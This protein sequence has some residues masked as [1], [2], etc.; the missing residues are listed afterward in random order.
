MPQN[1]RILADLPCSSS[2]EESMVKFRI[3]SAAA[4]FFA[5]LAGPAMARQ[6]ISGPSRP[7]QS[8]F[9]A[10]REA[11]NP[12]SKYCDY[13][14]WSKWRQRGDWDSTLD[15]ACLRNP[16]FIPGECSFDQQGRVLFSAPLNWPALNSGATAFDWAQPS[17]TQGV[18]PCSP[19]SPRLAAPHH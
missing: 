9:C 7:A 6:V 11:G 5:V 4:V 12:H 15:N 19:C 10:T 18:A 14:A 1:S 16:Y 8:L 13:L 3:I 2:T 17:A